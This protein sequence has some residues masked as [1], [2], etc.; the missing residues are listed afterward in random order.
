MKN[1]VFKIYL[2]IQSPFI[3]V[4]VLHNRIVHPIFSFSRPT[5]IHLQL[6]I[7][8]TKF[9][10]TRRNPISFSNLSNGL[11]HKVFLILLVYFFSHFPY[12]NW[13]VTMYYQI[14]QYVKYITVYGCRTLEILSI[15]FIKNDTETIL[16]FDPLRSTAWDTWEL[17]S[18]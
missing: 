1:K 14:L 15:V 6:E 8:A 3:N 17:S 10:L 13:K 9:D 7:V 16:I 18:R 12:E 5:A 11:C 4:N 2:Q